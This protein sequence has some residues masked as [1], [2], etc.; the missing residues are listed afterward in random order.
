MK[1][2]NPQD[3]EP[4]WIKKWE[5][6]GLYKTSDKTTKLKYY[7]LVMFPYS[8]GDLHIGHWYNFAPADIHARYKRMLGLE[9][10]NPMGFDSFGL[11]AENAAIKKGVH[12]H[13]WTEQ[14]VSRMVDQLKTT[15]NSYDW[16]RVVVASR[17]D[18]YKW[19]Q[20]MF[21]LM[22]KKGLAYRT[23][24]LANWCPSCQT[25]LANEQVENGICWRCGSQVTQKEIEQW[26][27][28]ITKYADRLLKDLEK[29]DWPEQTIAMQK[30]WIGRSEGLEIDFA[31]ENSDQKIKVFTTRADT[32]WGAT[33][34]VL[35][36]EHPLALLSASSERKKEVEDYIKEA[37]R[38][39][40]L[41]RMVDEKDT[42]G[43][44][45]GSYCINP[46]SNER[47]PVY[48]S[49]YVL[50]GYGTGAIM[51]VPAHDTRDNRFARKYG[52]EIREVIQPTESA[53]KSKSSETKIFEG[54]GT[55]MCSGNYSGKNSKEVIESIKEYV[56]R[57]H[58]GN[59][60]VNYHLRD[61]VVSRQRYWGA[62]IPIIYCEDCG[63]VPVSIIELPVELPFDVDYTPKGTS[64]LGTSNSFVNTVCPKCGKIAK[65]E[66]D[67]MDTFVDSSWY[68]LRFPTPNLEEAAF[69]K[70]LVDF[71]LPV[72]IYIG[73]AE[74]TVL[75]LLYSR[76]F[77]K[78]LFDE[79]LINFDEPFFRLRHQG[80]ILG[81]DGA[82]MSKSKGNVINPDDLV[83]TYG[84]DTVRTYLAF[85]GPYDQGGPWSYQGIEGI[86][87]YINRVWTL[88]TSK[89]AQEEIADKNDLRIMN[90]TIKKVSKDIDILHFNT[91]VSTLMEWL[92][93]LNTKK[94]VSKQEIEVYLKLL[95]PFAPFITE[96]IWSGMGNTESIHTQ[97]WPEFDESLIAEDEITLI[98]QINGKVRDRVG[99]P[100]N[101]DQDKALEA[102]LKLS[103]VKRYI[104]NRKDYRIIFVP[105]K[106]INLVLPS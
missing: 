72:D 58:L 79:G 18:Y 62:P 40:E 77:T 25:V 76:F 32:I 64:P 39:R 94:S 101:T 22:Y 85:M 96:E 42:T 21:L 45:T 81:P 37:S 82:K 102:S 19:T 49:E 68:F 24:A 16:G 17:P 57:D 20:W 61:W 53:K 100:I 50:M 10:L 43:V 93:Y 26:V 8:S 104:G 15:G 67:T 6:S 23:K 99:L 55:L 38:K 34:V 63:V 86:Y 74:H 28:S 91:A 27:F 97:N 1:K 51:G 5:D 36:P 105:N 87:R 78:V 106:L 65:R 83:K 30:N 11:P 103:N 3:I 14:N 54:F 33:F 48:V 88:T 95:A 60:K 35:A 92:N 13:E 70:S 2:Y 59:V 75:H 66:T 46:I 98:V 7:N 44:F 69:D 31:L 90:R 41:E 73:G 56:E 12:P 4:K 47:I 89:Q 52:L 80:M 29:I 9:V 84:A 71:W